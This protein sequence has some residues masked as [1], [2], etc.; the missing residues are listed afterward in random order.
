MPETCDGVRGLAHV[1]DQALI[2]WSGSFG[3]FRTSPSVP[4]PNA[5]NVPTSYALNTSTCTVVIPFWLQDLNGN[6][7][8]FDT[9]ISARITSIQGGAR[10]DWTAEVQNSRIGSTTALGGTL[11]SV[12]VTRTTAGGCVGVSGSAEINVRTP[13]NNVTTLGVTF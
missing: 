11:H 1:R 9:A 6:P 8:P 10:E 13:K 4:S 2:V 5:S 7:M 12:L 3:F